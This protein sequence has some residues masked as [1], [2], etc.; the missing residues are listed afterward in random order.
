[1]DRPFANRDPVA[2]IVI[3]AVKELVAMPHGSRAIVGIRSDGAL[4]TVALLQN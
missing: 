2:R 3:Q 4:G 1:V